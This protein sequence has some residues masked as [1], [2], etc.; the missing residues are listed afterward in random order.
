MARRR[1]DQ[2][3]VDRTNT[4]VYLPRDLYE[5]VAKEAQKAD[6]SVNGEIIQALKHWLNSK[7]YQFDFSLS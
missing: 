6:R 3:P 5:T 2:E 4:H 1:K 7:G